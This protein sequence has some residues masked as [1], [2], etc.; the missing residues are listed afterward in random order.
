MTRSGST[1]AAG[2]VTAA[3][4]GPVRLSIEV[5]APVELAFRVFTDKLGTWWPLLSH[6]IAADEESVT[7]A[8]EAHIEGQPG[9][10]IY[11]VCEDGSEADW[12]RVLV[13]DPPHRLVMSWKPSRSDRPP[14]EL[15]VRFAASGAG[16]VVSLEHRGWER[17]GDLGPRARRGYETGWPGV[18]ELYRVR[19]EAVASG[20]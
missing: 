4:N 11:E 15:E 8:V 17:L 10:R 9:G 16:T 3:T 5:A 1:V 14:T 12:G 18:L 19:A 6:S 7:R 20:G 13:W 2:A